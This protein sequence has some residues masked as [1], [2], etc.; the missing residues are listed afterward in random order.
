[1]LIFGGTVCRFIIYLNFRKLT[2]DNALVRM[3]VTDLQHSLACFTHFLNLVVTNAI[4]EDTELAELIQKDKT[5]VIYFHKSSKACDS[6]TID[7][8]YVLM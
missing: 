2:I 1:M 4:K 7:Q 8:N 3:I 6:L 5:V